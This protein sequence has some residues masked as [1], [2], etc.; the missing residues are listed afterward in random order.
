MYEDKKDGT[1]VY[2]SFEEMEQD[3]LKPETLWEKIK[4]TPYRIWDRITDWYI[5]IVSFF[6]RGKRGYAYSDVWDFDSYLAK[7]LYGGL[8][9]L[10]EKTKAISIHPNEVSYEEWLSILDEMIEGFKARVECEDFEQYINNDVDKK[11]KR[12]LELLS[13]YFNN[14]WW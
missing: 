6:Q 2:E 3:L 5:S 13:K 8:S 1:I 4:Y 9:E 12:S 10:K 11:L 7:V 14:L